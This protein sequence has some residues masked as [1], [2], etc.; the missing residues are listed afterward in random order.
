MPDLDTHK[1]GQG[2]SSLW[3][4]HGGWP[5][6]TVVVQPYLYYIVCTQVIIW[7]L[8]TWNIKFC[9]S[10]SPQYWI[11]CVENVSEPLGNGDNIGRWL[12]CIYACIVTEDS[13]EQVF[14]KKFEIVHVVITLCMYSPWLCCLLSVCIWKF[15]GLTVFL[16]SA[17]LKSA[18]NLISSSKYIWQS[19]TELPNLMLVMT[20]WDSTAKFNIRQYFQL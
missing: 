3:F 2:S 15:G 8:G 1:L 14:D 9:A 16:P 5:V 19:G 7:N 18:K 6:L 13:P 12:V 11:P 4:S 17:K 10:V 20:I